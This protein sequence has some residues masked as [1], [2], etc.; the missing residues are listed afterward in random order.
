MDAVVAT[1]L[2]PGV[3]LRQMRELAQLPNGDDNSYEP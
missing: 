1:V 3:H 2:T